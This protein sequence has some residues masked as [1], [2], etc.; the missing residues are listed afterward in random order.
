MRHR[1]PFAEC[2]ESSPKIVSV[3]LDLSLTESRTPSLLL[4]V[5]TA[6]DTPD[7]FSPIGRASAHPPEFHPL[8]G[9]CP[10]LTPAPSL[11]PTAAASPP[12]ASPNRPASPG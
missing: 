5:R 10:V 2:H 4:A 7:D 12:P 9:S 8:A 1:H 11:P 6:T 3:R